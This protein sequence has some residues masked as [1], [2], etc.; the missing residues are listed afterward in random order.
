[1]RLRAF[2]DGRA[3][4][5]MAATRAL[6]ESG[7]LDALD[8]L[9]ASGGPGDAAQVTQ[10]AGLTDVELTRAL[11]ELGDAY[12]LVR[13]RATT[14]ELTRRGRSLVRD[15]TGRAM[16]EALGGYHV[17][18]YR[19]LPNQLRGG[20]G[21]DDLE[22]HAELIARVSSALAPFIRDTV[23]AAASEGQPQRVLDIGCGEGEYLAAVLQRSAGARGVGLETDERVAALARDRLARLGGRGQV[24]AGAAPGDLG[25]AA[26]ALGGPADLVLLANVIYY[27]PPA[28]RSAFLR[29]VAAVTAPGGTVLVV[30]SV[31]ES[32]TESRHMGL[33]FMAQRA[34]MLLPT[35]EGLV[36]DMRRAGLEVD[37]ARRIAPG[38]P[39]MAATGR[40]QPG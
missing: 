37:R 16:V 4:I 7:L 31:A 22:K 13:R 3:A 27:V 25:R 19:E 20:A 30:T 10:R 32:T 28:D 38:E 24:L 1:M 23:V 18:L 33:L 39:I 36:A 2:R 5:R 14:W 11:L 6:L 26:D 21:R 17:D 15:A 34:P 12:G 8:A 35:A 9:D 40:R 29:D